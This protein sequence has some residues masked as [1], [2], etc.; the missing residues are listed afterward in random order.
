MGASRAH[1]KTKRGTARGGRSSRHARP[2]DP[3]DA[4]SRSRPRSHDRVRHRALL[5]GRAGCRTRVALSGAAPPGEPRLDLFLPL[6]V[7][8]SSVKRKVFEINPEIRFSF[9]AL[10]TQVRDGLMRERLMARL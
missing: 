4:R 5:A 2:A 1:A 7:L 8:V 6:D 10:K 9:Q 3:P